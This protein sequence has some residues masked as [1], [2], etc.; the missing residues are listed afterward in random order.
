MSTQLFGD[1]NNL[2]KTIEIEIKRI[3]KKEVSSILNLK[4]V[5]G[6]SRKYV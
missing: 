4:I 1:F 5:N 6:E 2:I 3:Y